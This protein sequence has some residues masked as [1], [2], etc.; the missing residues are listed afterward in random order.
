MFS[1]TILIVFIFL[2]FLFTKFLLFTKPEKKEPQTLCED[3]WN[4]IFSFL[5]FPKDHHTFCLV[6]KE[7]KNLIYSN[8]KYWNEKKIN[9]KR[10]CEIL[11]KCERFFFTRNESSNQINL[12]SLIIE[13]EITDENIMFLIEK[14]PNIEMLTL[15]NLSEDV[16]FELFKVC[17][18]I[19]TLKLINL[20][21]LVNSSFR[22]LIKDLKLKELLICSLPLISEKG[23]LLDPTNER[24]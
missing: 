11:L 18:K 21:K 2:F 22:R 15:R 5:N 23:F 13:N 19:T 6:N 14:F 4:S 20:P 3:C 24:T 9:S 8:Y 1:L 12:T 16:D 7:F 17:T 10:N